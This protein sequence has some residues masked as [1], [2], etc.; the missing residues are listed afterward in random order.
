M[1]TA[2]AVAG[3]R[4]GSV[5]VDI[6]AGPYGG[7]VEVSRPDE[8]VVV[9]PGVIVIGAGNLASDMAPA[10]SRAYA[11]NM[12]AVLAAII[13]DGR[14]GVPTDDDVIAAMTVTRAG[15]VVH[16]A[17]AEMTEPSLRGEQ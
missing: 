14:I 5:V 17:L 7:N 12:A 4:P 2:A 10:A 11:R 15:R 3:M 1:V 8:T 13:A 16:P 9:E 6:A